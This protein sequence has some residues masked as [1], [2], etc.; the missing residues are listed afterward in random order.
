MFLICGLLYLTGYLDSGLGSLDHFLSLLGTFTVSATSLSFQ[1]WTYSASECVANVGFHMCS[2]PVLLAADAYCA[3]MIGALKCLCGP[4]SV[5][6]M[7]QKVN[8]FL[9]Q[10]EP[11]AATSCC[12]IGCFYIQLSSYSIL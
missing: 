9:R 12:L 8:S 7:L 3:A 2:L 11:L 5:L 4:R 10:F 1:N 6:H